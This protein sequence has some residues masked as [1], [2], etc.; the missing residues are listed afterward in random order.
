MI[1]LVGNSLLV[2]LVRHMAPAACRLNAEAESS[3]EAKIIGDSPDMYSIR[4]LLLKLAWS[5]TDYTDW[6]YL[7]PVFRYHLADGSSIV[8]RWGHDGPMSITKALGPYLEY[9]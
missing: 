3:Q 8:V 9:G 6:D 2:T 5:C 7:S 4:E 1:S